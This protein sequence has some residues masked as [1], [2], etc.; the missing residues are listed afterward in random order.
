MM[1]LSPWGTHDLLGDFRKSL[2][3][4]LEHEFQL[5]WPY[6]ETMEGRRHTPKERVDAARQVKWCL[7][8][9]YARSF[10]L[11]ARFLQIANHWPQNVLAYM[12]NKDTTFWNIYMTLQ[13][14]VPAHIHSPFRYCKTCYVQRPYAVHPGITAFEVAAEYVGHHQMLALIKKMRNSRHHERRALAERRWL[15][16]MQQLHLIMMSTGFSMGSLHEFVKLEELFK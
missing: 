2:R 14:Y 13:A 16:K 8:N 10:L 9:A 1:P 5:L 6:L 15:A 4:A 12:A 11:P 3:P 7:Q